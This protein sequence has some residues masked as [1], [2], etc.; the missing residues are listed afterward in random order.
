MSDRRAF[1]AWVGLLWV[2]TFVGAAVGTPP[3]PVTQAYV[4]L[5][6]LVLAVPL[7]YWLTYRNGLERLRE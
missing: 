1:L 4:L 3:D 6:G 2:L 7:A 5:P